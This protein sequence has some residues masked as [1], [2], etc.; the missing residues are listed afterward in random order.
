MRS[1]KTEF[2]GNHRAAKYKIVCI[3]A[4]LLAL[5]RHV[6]LSSLFSDYTKIHQ[7]TSSPTAH[8]C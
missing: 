1:R 8:A 4:A 6:S 5:I 3:A 7:S 2:N